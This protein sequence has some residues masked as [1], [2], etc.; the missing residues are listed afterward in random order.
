MDFGLKIKIAI[1][2][3]AALL[4]S[5]AL[6]ACANDDET[7]VYEL[8]VEAGSGIEIL[9]SDFA[10]DPSVAASFAAAPEWD[11]DTAGD[12]TVRINLNGKE[13][14]CTLHVVDGGSAV[15]PV[16]SQNASNVR[17]EDFCRAEG[18]D[19]SFAVLPQISDAE[20]KYPV[21]LSV[22]S[23]TTLRYKTFYCVDRTAP[24]VTGVPKIVTVEKGDSISYR[25]GVEVS[26]SS[27]CECSFYLDLAGADTYVPGEYDVFCV[28]RDKAGN[29]TRVPV[30]L[31]VTSPSITRE[32]LDSVVAEIVPQIVNDGMTNV[33]K[34]AA[35]HA[36]ITENMDYIDKTSDGEW[37]EEAYLALQRGSGACQDFY[38]VSRAF[39]TYIGLENKCVRR[40]DEYT[41]LAGSTHL[42]NLVNVGTSDAP[43]WYHF[44]ATPKA[45]VFDIPSHCLTD[46]Q[47]LAYSAWRN[48][49]Q[50]DGAGNAVKLYF[51][52][53]DRDEYPPSSTVE[54]V[55][56]D[57]IPEKYY[58]EIAFSATVTE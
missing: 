33:E 44:D 51:Y 41:A 10:L 8:Y 19:V 34:L 6:C 11:L 28:A 30:R 2:S 16:W 20:G 45:G 40:S 13:L 18:V 29:E 7:S 58:E 37:W 53:F 27:G 4:L 46:E 1:L 50:T 32:M 35:I 22:K 14:E 21:L 24:Q 39:I 36:Y 9:A 54:I 55:P 47:V 48:A 57:L 5:F 25:D 23:E 17:A 38:A 3:L 31:I 56:H 26:D 49:E 12:Y 43:A 42:W 52:C 15:D